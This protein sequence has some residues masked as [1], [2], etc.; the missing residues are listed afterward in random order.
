MTLHICDSGARRMVP[1]SIEAVERTF[2]PGAN[3]NEGT[4]ITLMHGDRWIMAFVVSGEEEPRK[5]FVSGNLGAT[6][7]VSDRVERSE[8]L[9][10]F[11]RFLEA[12]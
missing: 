11:R 5:F 1:A 3:F 12:A 6:W 10:Q 9:R 8:A 2:S 7:A 4:E